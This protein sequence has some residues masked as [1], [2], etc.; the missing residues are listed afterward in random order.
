M[1]SRP[2]TR[3]LMND[4]VNPIEQ[5][6]V[7]FEHEY[8]LEL[9]RW[10]R[11]RFRNLCIG[12]FSIL[13]GYWVL[14]F[15]AW[16][17]DSIFQFSASSPRLKIDIPM[18]YGSIM[19]IVL[20]S[21]V[22]WFMVVVRRRLETKDQLIRSATRLIMLLSLVD[23]CGY[24]LLR[25]TG[26][27]PVSYTAFELFF[28]HFVACL[29][30]PWTPWQ[31]LKAIGPAYLLWAADLLAFNVSSAVMSDGDGMIILSEGVGTVIKLAL[32][33]MI[34]LPGVAICWIRLRRH[35]RRF[36][37]DM[38]GRQFLSLRRE[39]QQARKIHDALF[40]EPFEDAACRF[41][42]EYTPQ[43]DIGGDFVFY[44]RTDATIRLVLLDVTGHGLT[45][46]LTVNRIHG[47]LQRIR[48]EYPDGDPAQLM[49][50][51]NRYFVLT[52][53]AHN[54][55]A[56]GFACEL[57]LTDGVIKWVNAG[58]PPAFVIMSDAEPR[59]LETTTVM[60][61]A[62]PPEDFEPEQQETR[63]KPG[64]IIVAYT[65]GVL[66]ARDAKGRMLGLDMLR[67]LVASSPSRSSWPER[68]R[69]FVS[70]HARGA[71][72]DD[73]LVVALSYLARASS[74]AGSLEPKPTSKEPTRA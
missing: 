29:F 68:I 33:T 45:A 7:Y 73:V 72:E 44:D 23:V 37:V 43:T 17:A 20:I 54:V 51:L 15:T 42:F 58:H 18:L 70:N 41:E 9:E 22:L 13:F 11:R 28:W 46:A 12:L 25:L 66:E 60:I 67:Q 55:Y 63:V 5:T 49:S 10:V 30:L 38:V 4:P 24:I 8:E 6:A 35:G 50:V 2:Y 61:G 19:S 52:L 31:S 56:T 48:G 47:E 39:L 36:K 53:A 3:T 65:D 27:G 32:V 14:F 69:G 57:D 59:E 26:L 16:L 64:D 1:G 21:I 62:L 40:P 74:S 34:F 71:F